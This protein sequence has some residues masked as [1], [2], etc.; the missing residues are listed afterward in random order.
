MKTTSPAPLEGT[1]A[2]IVDRLQLHMPLEPRPFRTIG[3]ELGLAEA[4]VLE[5]VREL[6]ERRLIR[7]MSAIFDAGA[8]GY[9]SSLVAARY[10]PDHLE[11]AAE[12][13]SSYPG[14]SHN[15]R[16]EHEFNL[17]YTVAVP[18]DRSLD[19]TVGALHQ[20][21]GAGSTRLLP[22][23]RRFKLG[24]RLAVGER[25]PGNGQGDEDPAAYG[26]APEASPLS[27]TD[28]AAV[29]A[30]QDDIPICDEPFLE[31]ALR[32]GFDS[33]EALLSVG[34]DLKQRGVM[35]RFSAI[36][37]H[38]EAGFSSNGMVVWKAN[39]R[40]CERLG[41]VLA[42]F[43][44]VTHCYQRPTYDDWPYSLFTM[45]HGRSNA[46]I[47]RCIQAMSAATGLGEFRVLYSTVEFKKRRVRYFTNEWSAWDSQHPAGGRGT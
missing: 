35:R 10:E 16:R 40:D 8:L 36:L 34:R 3:K 38:R 44:E 23:L 39:E 19:T 25:S 6:K 32:E 22:T 15:Y 2:A 29:R 7:Q 5:Q 20:L 1:A 41:P 45:I 26:P 42:R 24:V 30:L 28:I 47:E 37:R 17:W 31:V 9:Q 13:I 11:A 12:V 27:A 18:G 4:D 46:D 43:P 14:V 33:A 21:S